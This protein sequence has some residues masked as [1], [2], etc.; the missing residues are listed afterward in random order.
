MIHSYTAINKEDCGETCCQASDCMLW[1]WRS[2]DKTCHLKKD[3]NSVFK[4]EKD[5]YTSK[6]SKSYFDHNLHAMTNLIIF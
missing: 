6:K 1:V 3:T 4:E 5:H 2:E